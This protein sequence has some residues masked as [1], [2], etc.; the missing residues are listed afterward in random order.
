MHVHLELYVD[1]L[2]MSLLLCLTMS[3]QGGCMHLGEDDL[4]DDDAATVHL[5]F[6]EL[7]DQPFCLIKA[8]ELRYAHA[9]KSGELWIPKLAPNLIHHSLHSNIKALQH[10]VF[11]GPRLAI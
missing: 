4:V 8:Q 7:L 3:L 1:T 2:R 9:Y 10:A 5:K 11:C 6:G